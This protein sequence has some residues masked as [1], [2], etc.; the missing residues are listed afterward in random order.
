MFGIASTRKSRR[1]RRF[2]RHVELVPTG[3]RGQ[4][5]RGLKQRDMGTYDE[6]ERRSYIQWSTQV[7]EYATSWREVRA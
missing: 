6:R 7:P 4:G 5:Y 1:Q 2:T 3:S